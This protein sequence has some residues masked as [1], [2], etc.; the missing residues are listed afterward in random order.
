MSYVG[1]PTTLPSS[2]TISM[3]KKFSAT[4]SQ[5]N[6]FLFH[7]GQPRPVILWIIGVHLM[8]WVAVDVWWKVVGGH[9][10]YSQGANL[11]Q[12]MYERV[13]G[14]KADGPIFQHHI[15]QQ[16]H[17]TVN[18]FSFQVLKHRQVCQWWHTPPLMV[19][20]RGAP[21][22]SLSRGYRSRI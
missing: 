16:S 11:A 12:R 9:C 21:L 3:T 19:G 10:Y 4:T 6:S 15:G 7:C 13:F 2:A 14:K 1:S 5:L 22:K 17:I 18:E 20:G 8:C